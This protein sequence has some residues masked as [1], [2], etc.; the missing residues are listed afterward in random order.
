MRRA[1]APTLF[2]LLLLAA[3]AAAHETKLP[4]EGVSVDVRAG[5]M[6]FSG[7]G[8]AISVVHDPQSEGFAVVVRGL[9]AAESR[10]ELIRLRPVPWGYVPGDGYTY[11]DF[12]GRAGG[13]TQASYKDGELT[14]RG[15]LEWE[16]GPV[17]V[18]DSLE[19]HI[20]A[21]D[22][23]Y[24][25][26]FDVA[27]LGAD[28][29]TN[30]GVSF[31]A[32]N[33]S[34]PA[35]CSDF[36]G[37]GDLE[38]GEECDDGN[39]V[40]DDGCTNQCLI[41]AC[42]GDDYA[43]TFDA[44]QEIVFEGYQ[45]TTCHN[46]QNL[47]GNLDLSADNAYEALL[48]PDLQ[49]A[50]AFAAPVKLVVPTE[51]EDSFLY[52]KLAGATLM[53]PVSAGSPMPAA[54]VP[55]T[56]EHLEAVSAWI[57]GG[58]P[59]DLVVEGTSGL[60]GTCLP[61]SDPLIVPIPDPPDPGLGVQL[62]QTARPLPSQE[63][64]EVC[65]ITYYDASAFV[66]PSARIP[67][68]PRYS[69][70]GLCDGAQGEA[71]S[72]DADCDPGEVCEG[73]IGVHNPDSECFAYNRTTLIQDP[74]SHHE[75]ILA[76]SGAAA[77][78][79]PEWGDWSKKFRDELHPDQGQPCDP[80]Q[81]T[82]GLPYNDGCSSEPEDSVACIGYGP[83]DFGELSAGT[84]FGGGGTTPQI[85]ISQ[86]P[87]SDFEF[88]DYAYDYLPMRGVIAWNSH[89]FNL[90][91]G[92]S[93]MSSFLNFE[94]AHAGER[95]HPV[96]KTFHYESIF[97]MA[98]PPFETREYCRTFTYPENTRLF[99]LSSH[100]HERG[101]LFRMWD[102]PNTPCSAG[103]APGANVVCPVL[104][105]TQL[106]LCAGPRLDAPMYYSPDYTDP[107]E[108]LFETPME[109]DS[110]DPADRSFLYCAQ[111]DN[112][113]TPQ[114]PVV[115]Q[116]TTSVDPGDGG[117]GAA[118]ILGGPCPDTTVAC[119]NPGDTQG[120]LCG[121]DHAVCDNLGATDGNCDACPVIGG[122][123]T[124]D[125]MFA[126]FTDFFIA[127]EPGMSVL[128]GVALLVVAALPRRRREERRR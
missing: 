49:G 11:L 29:L 68:P 100:M 109:L 84:I 97:A 26:E 79:H 27:S 54:G 89:A 119:L 32:Q 25:S 10:T 85:L 22:Q 44:I 121:G 114:P 104:D 108:L 64:S 66:P 75:V 120:M 78:D 3:S 21:G 31:E 91:N 77:L 123:T 102:P 38:D 101:V 34:A 117:L 74:Q 90:T 37:N 42:F 36:C 87:Y 14:L 6:T 4:F 18:L 16:W 28:V 1:A 110:S 118:G 95:R 93:T 24:C 13:I 76:Y 82:P 112:G 23:W 70:R 50:D 124:T 9:G 81:L 127:P 115:K 111:Y 105:F 17:G 41:G 30:D 103:C 33:A 12:A 67:C 2:A 52:E 88:A 80:E 35:S 106:P 122:V 58:A 57:R 98:V 19:V 62:Q 47:Q 5:D 53:T 45:C 92:D 125:E 72:D 40:E 15:L 99:R 56:L 65:M 61:A 69:F 48:G 51:P 7:A 20:Q 71:C 46:P 107:L 86:E 113:S 59:E 94:F 8:P 128:G 116:Q 73:T 60:L 43:S 96:T 83:N 126:I 39:L 55:L 63:E